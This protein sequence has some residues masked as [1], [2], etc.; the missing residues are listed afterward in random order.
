MNIVYMAKSAWTGLLDTIRSKAGVTGSMTV[1]QAAEAVESISGGDD[2]RFD[3]LVDRTISEVSL[4]TSNI[5]GYAFAYCSNLSEISC[6]NTLSIGSSAFYS[7]KMLKSAIFPAAV[8]ISTGAF[9]NCSELATVDFP[10]ISSLAM[11]AFANCSKL[12]SI[13]FPLVAMIPNS[14]FQG[15]WSLA[16]ASFPKLSNINAYAFISCTHLISLYLTGSTRVQLA[17][18]NAFNSTPIK[19]YT[20]STGGVY[21]SIFVPASLYDEYVSAYNWTYFSS[22]FVSV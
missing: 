13:S 10:S 1:S 5:G 18:S 22:R 3:A 15:C 12:S 20:T 8:S 19:G 2:G 16:T 21:G 7:C 14:T 4:S 6:P 9:Y 17:N 11:S